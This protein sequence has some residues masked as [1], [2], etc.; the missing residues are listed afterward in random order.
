MPVIL[1]KHKATAKAT[2]EKKGMPVQEKEFKMGE[3]LSTE[4]MAN[5]GVAVGMTK[6]LGN[7]ESV[8]VQISLHMPCAPD[9]EVI[10]QTF[11]FIEEW[12]DKKMEAALAETVE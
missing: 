6:N 1:T 11:A 5:V 9:S 2:I 3:V 12:V 8:K 4:A 7:Y 10:D